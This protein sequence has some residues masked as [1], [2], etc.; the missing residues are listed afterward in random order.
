MWLEACS[1][2]QG[3]RAWVPLSLNG[4]KTVKLGLPHCLQN[5]PGPLEEMRLWLQELHS[6]EGLLI[7]GG[8]QGGGRALECYTRLEPAWP[9]LRGCLELAIWGMF[10]FLEKNLINIL[11]ASSTNKDK[12]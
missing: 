8:Q 5:D 4:R 3:T 11:G 2:L 7:D 12:S 6:A 10:A 1:T 9:G